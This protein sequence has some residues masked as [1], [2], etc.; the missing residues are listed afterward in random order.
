LLNEI[1]GEEMIALTVV[2][3]LIAVPSDNVAVEIYV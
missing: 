3:E 2:N 1:Y